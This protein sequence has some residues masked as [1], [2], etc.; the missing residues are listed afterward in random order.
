MLIHIGGTGWCTH[1]CLIDMLK[2]LVLYS[3]I[4]KKGGQIC[5]TGLKKAQFV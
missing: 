4:F 5:K 1:V 2:N 3:K